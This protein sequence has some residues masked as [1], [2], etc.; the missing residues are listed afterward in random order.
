MTSSPAPAACETVGEPR[1]PSDEGEGNITNTRYCA[2]GL[3]DE[4]CGVYGEASKTTTVYQ[5]RTCG[6]EFAHEDDA[7]EHLASVHGMRVEQQAGDE[8][9]PASGADL[10][11]Q[12]VRT[13]Y[14]CQQ[15]D[16]S[17]ILRTTYK[18]PTCG[19]EYDDMVLLD[20]HTRE[21]HG[22]GILAEDAHDQ[23]YGMEAPAGDAVFYGG[24][25]S[26]GMEM[27]GEAA[28]SVG[29]NSCAVQ[30]VTRL[31]LESGEL[32]LICPV[33]QAQLPCDEMF[34][35]Q[36]MAAQHGQA[37]S[38]SG[39]GSGVESDQLD[40]LHSSCREHWYP[41]RDEAQ[42]RLR[43][44]SL[45]SFCGVKFSIQRLGLG[46]AHLP[47][48]WIRTTSSGLCDF[49]CGAF[50]GFFSVASQCKVPGTNL[51]MYR[52]E[53]HSFW[54]DDIAKPQARAKLLRRVERFLALRE[55]PKDL[56]F[57]RSCTTTDEL[58]GVEALY[59]ALQERFA[60][61]RRLLLAVVA[62]GQLHFE[63]PIRHS[64]LPGVIFYAQP[65]ADEAA[66]CRGE[67]YCRAIASALDLALAPSESSEVRLGFGPCE[68]LGI[69][70][71]HPPRP[72]VPCAEAL[73]VGDTCSLSFAPFS[74]CDAGLHSGFAGLDCFEGPGA[75]HIDL[76]CVGGA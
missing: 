9:A 26:S 49:V 68:A 48:D 11:R 60:G 34:L 63:G 38:Q 1:P 8:K 42:R 18:C 40:V 36:H 55:D 59:S 53:R 17:I 12:V 71:E 72:P 4:T 37:L 56:L 65:L 52:S 41:R 44:V 31:R 29:R 74:F 47:F 3:V 16:G 30:R 64:A 19:E 28:I 73:L 5:C 50:E 58:A 24:Q 62:D 14:R 15:L 27:P 43:I 61:P 13:T 2:A 46:D 67:G 6:L 45:G 22:F 7:T 70:E 76:G 23:S 57:V 66:A 35:L 75:R 21:Y 69:E 32:V 33:C 51:Q 20:A 39:G 25:Q 10:G 54:H